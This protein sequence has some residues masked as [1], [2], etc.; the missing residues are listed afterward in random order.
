MGSDSVF[1]GRPYAW[2]SGC[3][4]RPRLLIVLID[5]FGAILMFWLSLVYPPSPSTTNVDIVIGEDRVRAR[6]R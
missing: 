4:R 3:S 1:T 6:R 5:I 2:P